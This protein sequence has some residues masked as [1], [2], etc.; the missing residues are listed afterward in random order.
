M[1]KAVGFNFFFTTFAQDLLRTTTTWAVQF[2]DN[3][4]GFDAHFIRFVSLTLYENEG[5]GHQNEVHTDTKLTDLV[6]K[7]IALFVG[8][9]IPLFIVAMHFYTAPFKK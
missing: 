9:I 7:D 5:L 6:I 4:T 3:H 2:L 8:I 1:F